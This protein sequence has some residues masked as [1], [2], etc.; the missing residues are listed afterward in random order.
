MIFTFYLITTGRKNEKN[1]EIKYYVK[2]GRQNGE[3]ENK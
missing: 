1:Y 2:Y 3:K